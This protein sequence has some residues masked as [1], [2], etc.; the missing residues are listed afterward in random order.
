MKLTDATF[1]ILDVE[2]TGVDPQKD[3]VVE[4]GVVTAPPVGPFSCFSNLVDP[5]I[6]I[7]P[8]ASAIH[9]LTDENVA[10]KPTLEELMPEIEAAIGGSILAAHEAKFDLSFLPTLADRPWI[11]TKRLARHIWPDAPAYNNQVLRYWLKLK[12]DPGNSHRAISDAIVTAHI[13]NKEISAYLAMGKPNDV[14]ALIEFLRGPVEV[15]T[16]PFGKHFGLPI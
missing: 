7:P 1:A 16:M 9:H 15:K 13:L 6:P 12:I 5:G 14:E 11:C 2:T 3:R 4:V 10:G 8:S